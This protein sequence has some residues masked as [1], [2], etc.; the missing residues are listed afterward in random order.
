MTNR[1]IGVRW[2][3]VGCLL[4]ILCG[5]IAVG[6]DSTQSYS[7][8][9][10]VVD[11]TDVIEVQSLV[12]DP[13]EGDTAS[14]ELTY[15]L[16]DDIT[17]LQITLPETDGD[18]GDGFTEV[19]ENIFEWDG[20]TTEP[21]LE[22]D[23]SV[24]QS[25]AGHDGLDFAGTD[26][27]AL[28]GAVSTVAE[29]RG[30]GDGADF[31]FDRTIEH[32]FEGIAGDE[33]AYVGPYESE[34]VETESGEIRVITADE[35]TPPRSTKEVGEILSETAEQF[36]ITNRRDA[37]HAYIVTDPIRLGGL[38]TGGNADFWVHEDSLDSPRTTLWHE[39][40]HSQQ[41][42]RP[43]SD[44]SWTIE[45]EA[46][47]YAYLLAMKQGEIEYH[48]FYSALE[49]ADETHSDAI[50]AEPGTWADEPVD[51]ELGALTLAA[52]D[53]EIREASAGTDTY[54]DVMETKN[55]EGGDPVM[56]SGTVSDS[57]FESFVTEAARTDM[58]QFF[59]S[60]IRSE[61]DSLIVPGPETYEV[62][63]TGSALTIE[64]TDTVLGAATEES[65]EFT[66]TNAG[67]GT[68]IAPFV[69]VDA[70][71]ELS[72]GQLGVNTNAGVASEVTTVE[73]GWAVDH[74]EPGESVVVE[75]LFDAP[76]DESAEPEQIDALVTDRG[77]ES[78]ATSS[79]LEVVDA[80]EISIDGPDV[81]AAG[82]SVTFEATKESTDQDIISYR[83]EV[84]GPVDETIETDGPE[85]SYE[86][87]E[88]G[89]YTVVLTTENADGA[90][91][92]TTRELLVNDQPTVTIDAPD[93]VS[94]GEEFLAEAEVT[95]EFGSYDL[96]WEANG[97][98]ATRERVKFTFTSDGEREL[99]VTVTD[100]YGEST[101][102]S[103]T[104]I[105]GDP[106]E[107]DGIQEEITDAF[108][109]GMG[110]PAALLALGIL[111]LGLRTRR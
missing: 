97:L 96:E 88:P 19:S 110:V 104:V 24:D 62:E 26:D 83:W 103:T 28:V 56:Q 9:E 37:L 48:D 102:E 71:E 12:S 63:P 90:T 74:L 61:P 27:W 47:Y 70:P 10:I 36:H 66:I 38:A 89:E 17:E 111:L 82:E 77:G 50:L 59:T 92:T 52:L 5:G 7:D 30:F 8:S 107:S 57:E 3:V 73:G 21:V 91:A 15:Y 2:V 16:G 101:T 64:T 84:T 6:A 44:V 68:S 54:K 105:V 35:T 81:I 11:D 86:F 60:Y 69:T 51:Y 25:A 32:E 18:P 93:E 22:V 72:D 23:Q 95:N 45:A 65:I 85:F 39:Y 109:P 79:E 53:S 78:A 40:I 31:S 76:A 14:Y 20:E 49:G 1:Q 34:I 29:F 75:Y 43:E 13:R 99:S 94:T 67:D 58:S 108:G 55:E 46:D 42:F 100:E 98:D 41:H 33:M 80:P 87:T 106:D 4:I